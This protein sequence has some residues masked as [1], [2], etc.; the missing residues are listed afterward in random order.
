MINPSER[1]FFHGQAVRQKSRVK[2]D[3]SSKRHAAIAALQLPPPTEQ[4]V[5]KSERRRYGVNELKPYI[6]CK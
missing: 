3:Q 5:T 6:L 4:W 1:L 2:E